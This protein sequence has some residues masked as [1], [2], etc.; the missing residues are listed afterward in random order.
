[1]YHAVRVAAPGPQ[2]P[3][4][5]MCDA[6]SRRTRPQPSRALRGHAA[7]LTLHLDGYGKNVQSYAICVRQA[8]STH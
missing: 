8:R 1:L 4:C 3:T 6:K 2:H 7:S 5:A